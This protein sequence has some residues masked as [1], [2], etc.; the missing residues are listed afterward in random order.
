VTNVRAPIDAAAVDRSMA[1]F[2]Q[3]RTLPADAYTSPDLLAWERRYFFDGSWVCVGR[4]AE[5]AE[6]GSQR[7]VDIGAEGV[8]IV[9]GADAT[10]RAFSNVCRHRG[11]QL[12][13]NGACTVNKA[14]V[15]PYHSWTYGLDGGLRGASS[16]RELEGFETSEFPLIDVGVAEW[17]GWAFV[18]ASGDA[19][20]FEEHVG[21]LGEVLGAYEPER[22]RPAAEHG[23]TIEANWKLI[24]ENYHECYHCSNIH[25]AL[26]KVTPVDS[27]LDYVPTGV[28]AG[29]NMELFDF[30]ST[31]SMD[32][33]SGGVRLRGLDDGRA[34]EV[35][36]CH[37]FPNLL[38][39]A[40]PDYVMTHRL[41]PRSEGETF[42]ECQWLF[43]PE[44]FELDG[45][46]PAYAVDFWD[47]TNREDWGACESV[48]R[49]AHYRGFRPGP[50]SPRETTVY[51]AITIIARGY[52]D[53]RLS[54]PA[55]SAARLKD[56][57]AA[58]A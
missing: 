36:Y 20:P 23:Y 2:G 22:L 8:L 26:C 47:V 17:G 49:A 37:L 41:V 57:S 50:L 43:P 9:R 16:F 51:Q 6:P 11:H 21:N 52:Q 45:F 14:I 31:M 55:V 28:W 35:Q 13:Q 4:S 25:P 32:G 54:P 10:L 46:S 12:L 38:V 24:A 48:Q 3:S 1:P 33:S 44:A 5:V 56:R 18:N 29:G 40:H 27:G 30:A 58:G 42:V 7:A 15:C 39:S 34:R 19:P 53:G